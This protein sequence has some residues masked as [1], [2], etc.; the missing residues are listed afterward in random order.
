MPQLKYD[1]VSLFL[2]LQLPVLQIF[3][4]LRE[5]SFFIFRFLS[6]MLTLTLTLA[7]INYIT[8]GL[9]LSNL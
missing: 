4:L 9:L 3:I 8:I 2:V 6:N 1:I 5:Q 7:G